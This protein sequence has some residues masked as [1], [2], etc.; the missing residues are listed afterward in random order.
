MVKSTRLTRA[1]ALTAAVLTAVAGCSSGASSDAG[2]TTTVNWW[3]WSPDQA[4]AYQ[5]CVPAF[6][7]ANPDIKVKITNYNVSDYFTKLTSGFVSGDAPD[8]F[9]NSV[10]FL[11]SYAGQGQ[12]LA[13]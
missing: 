12:L 6:E 3:T 1:V 11:Q 4:I 10:T 2:G 9:M 13:L 7:K 8:A 5:Q